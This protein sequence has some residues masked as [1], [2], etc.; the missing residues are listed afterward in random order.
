MIT[1]NKI[2]LLIDELIEKRDLEAKSNRIYKLCVDELN[3]DF[4]TELKRLKIKLCN[5]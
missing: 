4:I 2:R 1:R 3:E 5:L